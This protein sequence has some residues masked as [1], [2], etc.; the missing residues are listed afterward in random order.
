M[1]SIIIPVFNV[2]KYISR[3]LDSILNQTFQDFE[4]ILV[5]DQATDNSIRIAESYAEKDSRIRIL[6]NEENSGA[7]WS[8]MIGYSNANGNYI[9]F[10]DPD[11]FLP[12][13]ALESLYNGI[14]QDENID[15]CIGNYQ[16]VFPDGSKSH[17]YENHLKYGQDKRGL[18]K[19]TLK[20]ETPHYLW[21]KIY[22]AELFKNQDI[23]T[24]KHFSKSSDE[25]LFFQ[26]LQNCN[27]A[28]TI[29]KVVYYYYDNNQSASYNKGT[30]EAL[31][32]MIISQQY[33]EN[34][35][36]ETNDF[37]PLIQK[38][39]TNKYAK[40]VI[41]AG[42]DKKLLKMIFDNKIDYLFTPQNLLKHFYKRKALKVFF[43]Y[44]KARVISFT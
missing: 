38:I 12:K 33:V 29:N 6:H 25:F 16:R 44:L 8:R 2:E 20:Y 15:I 24:Y 27:K 34:L 40:F 32:A 19:S 30:I 14:V 37:K 13:D 7:A 5:N 9:T 4:I 3:C 21:N 36:K 26:I 22:K 41:V 39:K 1:I 11:D 42:T 17:I 31:K 18:A 23:I 43:T 10:C 35:Y 28:V